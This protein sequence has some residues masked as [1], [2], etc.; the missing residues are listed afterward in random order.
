MQHDDG[1]DEGRDVHEAE[2]EVVDEEVA[3]DVANVQADAVVHEAVTEPKLESQG[4]KYAIHG[5]NKDQGIRNSAYS[6]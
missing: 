2:D 5:N 1:E 6:P 3:A 4:V